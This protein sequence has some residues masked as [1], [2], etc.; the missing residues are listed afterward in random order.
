[1]AKLIIG[2][3]VNSKENQ[4]KLEAGQRWVFQATFMN[5]AMAHWTR[6]W[7]TVHIL[8]D[9]LSN[10]FL[11][12]HRSYTNVKMSLMHAGVNPLTLTAMD[13]GFMF[14]YA[15]G[16]FITGQLGDRFSPVVVVGLG[17]LGSTICLLLI[18]FGAS[19]SIISNVAL[20]GTWFL[21]CQL[22]HG[23]FQA[24]GGPV[25]DLIYDLFWLLTYTMSM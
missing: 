25:T 7:V 23:A 4:A 21:T 1:M 13:S 9:L 11:W 8:C 17:L 2:S 19:T 16:S 18:V 20:C 3:D 6:K 5:Y 10:I 24:T 22:L 15:G 14:T 12:F